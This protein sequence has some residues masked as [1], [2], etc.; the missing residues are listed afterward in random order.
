MKHT[1]G[2]WEAFKMVLGQN[3]KDRRSGMVVNGPEPK[4]K[5]ELPARICDM[6]TGSTSIIELR[7]NAKLIAAAPD[8]YLACRAALLTL[9]DD[10]H[11]H[12][13]KDVV[14]TLR[15]AINKATE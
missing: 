8:L 1:P 2:P 7:A 6:R 15:N 10:E 11:Y 13:C 3:E 12:E 5:R 14:E 9:E 4:A